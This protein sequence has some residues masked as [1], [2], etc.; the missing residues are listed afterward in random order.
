MA[1]STIYLC[2]QWKTSVLLY[3]RFSLRT[4][5]KFETMKAHP[6]SVAVKTFQERIFFS[7]Q[8]IFMQVQNPVSKYKEWLKKAH[9]T[10]CVTFAPSA[11]L[12]DAVACGIK[13][14]LGIYC[15]SVHA[16]FP[17][18]NSLVIMGHTHGPL[19][20]EFKDFS[21]V[22]SGGWAATGKDAKFSFV[23]VFEKEIVLHTLHPSKSATWNTRTV[24]LDSRFKFQT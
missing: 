20:Q 21:Y 12:E 6:D 7:T 5:R 8:R 4:S 13:E 1:F 3:P 2:T 17:S 24:T 15:H 22:N 18:T 23:E 11:K 9:G 16:L 14:C 10:R 19:V